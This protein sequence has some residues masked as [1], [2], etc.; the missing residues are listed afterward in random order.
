VAA[1]VG[2]SR[3]KLLLPLLLL[4]MMMT[5]NIPPLL[6]GPSQ[7]SITFNNLQAVRSQLYTWHH[8]TWAIKVLATQCC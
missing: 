8:H 2:R 3:C 6:H 7:P 4:L 1:L 5:I